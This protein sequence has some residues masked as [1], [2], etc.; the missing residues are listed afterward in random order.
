MANYVAETIGAAVGSVPNVLVHAVVAESSF[1]TVNT[2]PVVAH[3]FLSILKAFKA[4]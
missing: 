4:E 3:A 1:L 2:P